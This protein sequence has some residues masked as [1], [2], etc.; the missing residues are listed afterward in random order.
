MESMDQTWAVFLM[1]FFWVAIGVFST[2]A[3]PFRIAFGSGMHND[4]TL[5]TT[6]ATNSLLLKMAQLK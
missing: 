3:M 2:L 6:E 1:A 4:Q 5:G